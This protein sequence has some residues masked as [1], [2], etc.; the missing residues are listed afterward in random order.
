MM[1]CFSIFRSSI[2]SW[3]G[4]GEELSHSRNVI[5]KTVSFQIVLYFCKYLYA[6]LLLYKLQ[7]ILLLYSRS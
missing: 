7:K 2:D 1:P 5:Q 3:G 4:W 6:F